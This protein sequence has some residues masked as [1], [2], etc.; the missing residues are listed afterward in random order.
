MN[1][2][3]VRAFVEV[4][5]QGGFSQ[6][7]EVVLLTQSAISKAVRT[8]EEELGVPLLN[9]LGHRCELTAAG[10]VVYRRALVMLAERDD[11]IAELKELQGLQRGTLRIGLPP[12][13]SGVLFSK[14][15]TAYR[16]RYPNIEIQLLEYGG[17]QLHECLQGGVVDLAAILAPLGPE[18]DGQD[19]RV[20]PLTVVLPA[21]HPLADR[22][23][24][25]FPTLAAEP[26][27]LF[28]EG[29]T[30]NRIILDACE[31]QGVAP[32]I[33]AR[34]AQIDFIVDLVK[35]ELGVAFL[36]RMLAEKYQ[37]HAIRLVPLAEPQT[38]WHMMLAW[39]RQAHLPAAARAWLELARE[40]LP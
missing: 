18:L 26:F 24:L 12:V 31:R 20:E 37:N 1:L 2:R 3:T 11:L 30:L 16:R 17:E 9:R 36:P 28:E 10:E 32:K 27:I 8:L 23:E 14:M 35:A 5:R 22:P 15:F 4:V 19:V 34:S 25:D 13:G 7:A 33:C 38:D 40:M 6:A 39:R 29:F 21:S